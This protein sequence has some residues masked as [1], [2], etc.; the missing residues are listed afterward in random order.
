MGVETKG[1]ILHIKQGNSVILIIDGQPVKIE[2]IES[3]SGGCRLALKADR[4]RVRILRDKIYM[5][6]E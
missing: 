6:E 4:Q 5:G 2:I 3:N 1:L